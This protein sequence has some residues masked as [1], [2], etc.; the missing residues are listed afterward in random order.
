MASPVRQRRGMER[1]IHTEGLVE[2]MEL[3]TRMAAPAVDMELQ[4]NKAAQ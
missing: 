2:A 1:R 4:G 3:P